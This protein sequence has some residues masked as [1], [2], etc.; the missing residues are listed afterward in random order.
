MREELAAMTRWSLRRRRGGT[1]NAEREYRPVAAAPVAGRPST[2]QPPAGQPVTVQAPAGQPGPSAQA[3]GWF[4]P[5]DASLGA[6]QYGAAQ[7]GRSLLGGGQAAN[8]VAMLA[9]VQQPASAQLPAP[10]QSLPYVQPA[11]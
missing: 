8:G 5:G 4:Q 6:G 10:A 2:A 7:Q 11:Q 3:G 1:R 9:P